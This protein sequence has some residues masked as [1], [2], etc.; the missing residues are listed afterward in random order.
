MSEKQTDARRPPE[1]APAYG[2]DHL[3]PRG[4]FVDFGCL[5]TGGVVDPFPAQVMS[6]AAPKGEGRLNLNVHELGFITPQF[7]VAYS[8]T[9]K[10]GCWTPRAD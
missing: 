3:P 6:E 9:P 1:S 2:P 10:V 4:A 8:P 7:K 5:G